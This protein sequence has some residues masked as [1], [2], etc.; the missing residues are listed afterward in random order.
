MKDILDRIQ[1]KYD[2]QDVKYRFDNQA[3]VTV[4]KD[5]AIDMVTYMRDY[6]GFSH[7]VMM[8]CVDWIEDNKLQLLYLLRNAK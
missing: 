4:G 6:E 7:F 1:P 5:L 2:L 3:Y 8:S